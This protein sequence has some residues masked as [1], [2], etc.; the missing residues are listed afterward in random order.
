MPAVTS[1]AVPTDWR[2][3][4]ALPAATFPIVDCTPAAIEPAAT[5]PVVNPA[6]AMRRG[7]ATVQTITT[8][9]GTR[10]ALNESDTFQR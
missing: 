5:P 6:P 3:A 8:A 7:G 2:N 9:A 10:N 4:K 1:G